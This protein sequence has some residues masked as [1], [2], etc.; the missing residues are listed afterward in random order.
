MKIESYDDRVR[1]MCFSVCVLVSLIGMSL[2][3][4]RELALEC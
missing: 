2:L 3:L 4:F 1:M